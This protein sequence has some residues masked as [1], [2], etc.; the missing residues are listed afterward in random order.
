M[1]AT[2]QGT[3]GRSL[4][5][6]SSSWPKL[7]KVR[8]VGPIT[9]KKWTGLPSSW[10]GRGTRA[11]NETDCS[12]VRPWAEILWGNHLCGFKPKVCGHL[13][14]SSNRLIH[15]ETCPCFV[16]GISFH[17]QLRIIITIFLSSFHYVHFFLL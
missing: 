15:K 11:S 7:Q 2:W 4:G 10:P 5:N 14:Y 6:E 12:L 3:V 16:D 17:L 8:N 9:A 1:G 13:L